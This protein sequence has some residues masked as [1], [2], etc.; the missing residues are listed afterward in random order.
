MERL[1]N[2]C[3]V[4]SLQI[5]LPQRSHINKNFLHYDTA[6]ARKVLPWGRLRG[7]TLGLTGWRSSLQIEN[8]RSRHLIS[9]VSCIVFCC[10]MFLLINRFGV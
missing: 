6:P 3:I 7:F 8:D 5:R 1:K 10:K 2:D 9:A 4:F